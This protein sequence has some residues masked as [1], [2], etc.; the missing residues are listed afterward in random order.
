[1]AMNQAHFSRTTAGCAN[2]NRALLQVLLKQR[3]SVAA[4]RWTVDSVRT[5]VSAIKND[6][7]RA[8]HL[9]VLT[10]HNKHRQIGGSSQ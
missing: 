5:K 9:T 6:S 10:F 2:H 8:L 1:M 7:H 3:T 4:T